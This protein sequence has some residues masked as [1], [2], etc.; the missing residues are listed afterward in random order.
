MLGQAAAKR[1]EVAGG[2]GRRTA[3]T[4]GLGTGRCRQEH[5]NERG[6]ESAHAATTPRTRDRF[7]QVSPPMSVA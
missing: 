3:A 1:L 5:N 6:D 7:R 4:T 2:R